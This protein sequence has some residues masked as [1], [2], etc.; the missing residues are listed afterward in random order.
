MK[1]VKL[2]SQQFDKFAA[3]HR[4][5]SY[6][7]SS[8]YANVMI[9]FGYHAQFLGIVNSENKLIGATLILYKEAFMGNKIAYAPRGILFNYEEE[10]DTKE[11][12]EN[13]KKVLGKQ[14]FI[15]LRMDPYIPL[16]IRDF[17]GNIMNLNN[18]GNTIINNLKNAGFSY[19]GKNVYFENEKPRFEAIILLQRDI[20]EIFAKLEKSTRNQIR[21][22]INNGVDVEKD[23]NKNIEA[24]Y[25]LIKKVDKKPLNYYKSIYDNFGDNIDIYFAKINTQSFLIS[26]RKN[27]EK[28]VEYN[29]SL[30]ARV[31]D[32]SLDQK[33]RDEYLSKKMESD[34]LIA[35]YKTNLV[36]ATELL[37]DNP[38]GIII[39]GAMVVKYDNAAYILA[40]ASGKDYGSLNPTYLLNW[41]LITDYNNLGFKYVNL[42]GITGDFDHS[43]K[44]HE[45]N[46]MKLG[47]NTTVAEYV[48]EFDIILNNFSYNLYK[49]MNKDK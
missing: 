25:D 8:M 48:G 44:Y 26:S 5:R 18:K 11:L 9:K 32:T 23:M 15:L 24:F 31:Q 22:A 39:A 37:R 3:T 42:D 6:F 4:Y 46:E 33:Y 41:K 10:Y 17:E 38:N 45:M 34:K 28:E 40:E 49:K 47:F 35:T 30:A 2:N 21:R 13:L 19:K 36:K 20:R 16:T 43:S 1:I 7:Q 14:N 29:D 27:Y 12:A